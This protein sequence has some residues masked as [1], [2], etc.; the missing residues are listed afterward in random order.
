MPFSFHL[1][2]RTFGIA[3]VEALAV[4]R[5]VLISNK[6]NIWREIAA[7]HAGMVDDDT[8]EGT[9]RMLRRWFNL[10]QAERDTMA[11]HARP[12]FLERYAMSRT[13]EA[14][15]QTFCL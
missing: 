5:P 12:C 8:R 3:V 6:V 1:I 2:L 4:G 7:D 13:V 14:I 10:P 9:E 15:N 11:A